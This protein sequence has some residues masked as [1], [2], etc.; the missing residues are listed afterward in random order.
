MN[1]A[2]AMFLLR[3]GIAFSFLYVAV[4]SLQNPANWVGFF[5]AWAFKVASEETT[6]FLFSGIEIGLA[7]W[8]ISG[9]KGVYAA[10]AAAAL[11]LGITVFNLG[12]L[13]IVFRDV[14]IAVAAIALV[15]LE[16]YANTNRGN[17]RE[18]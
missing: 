1:I 17:K 16:L 3:G 10:S 14:S 7:L 15:Q 13:D 5:P 12:A 8:L 6:L 18:N 2:S 11:L 4:A 9:K